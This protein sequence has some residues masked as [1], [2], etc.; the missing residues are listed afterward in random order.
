[1]M[2]QIVN[3]AISEL[4]EELS[5]TVDVTKEPS[6]FIRLMHLKYKC[7]ILLLLALLCSMLI[8]YVTIQEI[9]RDEEMGVIMTKLFDL[10]NDKYF[11]NNTL[12]WMK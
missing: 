2:E 8:G 5:E 10:V 4:K 1:M 11:Q 9:L 7:F 6:R 3:A 12:S